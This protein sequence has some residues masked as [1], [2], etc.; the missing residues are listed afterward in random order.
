M[1]D[2]TDL[3]RDHILAPLPDLDILV[4]QKLHTVGVV[5]GALDPPAK[6]Q[7]TMDKAGP[8]KKLLP[9]MNIHPATTRQ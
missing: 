3:V 8:E 9:H 4:C 5:D 6:P 2:H 1:Q 7:L